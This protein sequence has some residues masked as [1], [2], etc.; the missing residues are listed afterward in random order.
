MRY[1]YTKISPSIPFRP[2]LDLVLKNGFA[3]QSTLGLVDSGADYSIFPYSFATVLKVDL[4]QAKM[5]NF[6]GTTGRLQS[7]YLA[8]IEIRIVNQDTGT[9]DFQLKDIEV[10]F[11]H[12]FEFPGGGLLGQKG[13]F[14]SFRTELNQPEQ[15]FEIHPVVP[16]SFEA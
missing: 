12:D 2:Y 6:A 10:A 15:S 4:S 13:F 14:S 16:A 1:T 7:A 11:C 5:W 9:V 8:N 3:T